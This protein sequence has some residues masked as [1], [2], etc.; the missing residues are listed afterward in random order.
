[1]SP[2]FVM[3]EGP[4]ADHSEIEG[5]GVIVTSPNGWTDWELRKEWFRETFVPNALAH[6]VDEK[7]IALWRHRCHS[8]DILNV[9]GHDSHETNSLKAITYGYGIIIIGF[10]LK[11]THKTQP[12]DVGIFSS[13]SR[14]WTSHCGQHIVEG[15]KIDHYNFIP[16]YMSICHVMTPT[17]IWKAFTCTEIYPF[18]PDIFTEKDFAPSQATSYEV[19]VPPLYHSS[20]DTPS[21]Q[22]TAPPSGPAQTTASHMESEDIIEDEG[23]GSEEFYYNSNV[24]DQIEAAAGKACAQDLVSHQEW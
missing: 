14:K 23:S 4:L 2:C 20:G 12:L 8:A 3:K 17:L 7:P 16:K 1:M 21:A 6:C 13:V 22:I 11:T 9:D 19:C 10:P 15:I 24:G 5:I 18:N